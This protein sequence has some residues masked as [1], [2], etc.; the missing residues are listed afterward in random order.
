MQVKTLKSFTSNDGTQAKVGQVVE[1]S[2]KELDT[3]LA[4]NYVTKD[5]TGTS[6][7]PPA[8]PPSR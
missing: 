3:R 1:L 7:H 6:G 8:S 2:G 4:E 5:L